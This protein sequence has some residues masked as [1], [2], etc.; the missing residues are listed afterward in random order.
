MRIKGEYVLREIAGDYILVPVGPSALEVNGM[1]TVNE[2]GVFIWKQLEQGCNYE[3]LL[4]SITAEYEVPDN[5][6]KID[7][8]EFLARMKDANLIADE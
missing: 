8:D 2:V 4:A 5:Q 3:E 1:I 7:L 6:A